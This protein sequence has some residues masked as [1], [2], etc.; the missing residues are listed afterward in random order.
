MT[1]RQDR[2]KDIQTARQIDR[3]KQND[4]FK[5]VIKNKYQKKSK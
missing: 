1:Y 4:S 2:H 5:I 3:H